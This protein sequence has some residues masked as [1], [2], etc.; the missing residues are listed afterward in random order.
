MVWGQVIQKINNIKISD[1]KLNY[2][3]INANDK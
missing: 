3:H 2:G 1:V